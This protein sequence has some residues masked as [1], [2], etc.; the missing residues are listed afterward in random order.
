[1]P[2]VMP[3]V[4]QY[5]M[6]HGM[7]YVMQYVMQFVMQFVERYLPLRR[8][9]RVVGDQSLQLVGRWQF[10]PPRLDLADGHVSFLLDLVLLL[11]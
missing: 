3:Y 7:Q 6:Q 5:A 10:T 8:W 1:M 2:Y 4:M 9:R 11:P